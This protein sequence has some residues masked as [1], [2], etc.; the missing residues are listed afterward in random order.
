M[1]VKDPQK[2]LV[3]NV[4]AQQQVFGYLNI[5]SELRVAEVL[6]STTA[7]GMWPCISLQEESV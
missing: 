3:Y 1:K 2:S 7:D 4:T 6:S 5:F